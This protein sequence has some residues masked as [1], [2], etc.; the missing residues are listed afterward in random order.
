MYICIDFDGTVV[1][2]RFPDIGEP[3]PD[4]IKWMKEWQRAGARLILFTMRSGKHLDEAQRWFLWH[5]IGLYGINHNP[6]QDSWSDSPKAYGHLYIDDAAFGCP[7]S[8]IPGFS[9]PSVEWG[10]VGP[11]VLGQ[12]ER[13][14]EEKENKSIT[15]KAK[16]D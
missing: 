1:D 15:T 5:N 9:R 11:L 8:T 14:Y 16:G 6:D 4:A 13:W 3:V 2:H 7:L 10:R 12:I